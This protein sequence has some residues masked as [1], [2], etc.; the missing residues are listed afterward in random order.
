MKVNQQAVLNASP[1]RYKSLSSPLF[2]TGRTCVGRP[3][4]RRVGR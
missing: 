2:A 3:L 4:I 1:S